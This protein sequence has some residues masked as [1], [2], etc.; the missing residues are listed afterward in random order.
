ME[1]KIR[2]SAMEPFMYFFQVMLHTPGD[3]R[4]LHHLKI[5]LLCSFSL[6]SNDILCQLRDRHLWISPVLWGECKDILQWMDAFCRCCGWSF[7][8]C[9]NGLT[10]FLCWFIRLIGFRIAALKTN[11][12]SFFFRKPKR[13]QLKH[14]NAWQKSLTF[15]VYSWVVLWTWITHLV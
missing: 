3:V 15:C 11:G 2:K 10:C 5:E 13:M 12:Y 1:K 4:P 14:W 7:T 8:G 6:V 9:L